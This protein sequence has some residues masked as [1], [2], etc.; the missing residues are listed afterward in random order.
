MEGARSRVALRDKR[1]GSHGA[2]LTAV[3]VTA[4]VVECGVSVE[5]EQT[6]IN[7]DERPL[8]AVYEFA[9]PLKAAV[10]GTPR[11]SAPSP[12]LCWPN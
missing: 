6:F 10:C 12:S 11:P 8:E 4:D 2:T 7:D 5:L 3:S 9:L 1:D